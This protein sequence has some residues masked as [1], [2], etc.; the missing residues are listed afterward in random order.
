MGFVSIESDDSLPLKREI[1]DKDARL[2]DR[3]RRLAEQKAEIARLSR[4]LREARAEVDQAKL[5]AARA[6]ATQEARSSSRAQRLA[7]Q[8][9]EISRLNRE[10]EQAQREALQAGMVVERLARAHTVL[11]ELPSDE[12]RL[13]VGTRTT[14]ANFLANGMIAADRVRHVFGDHPTGLV[15]DWGC[16][17][18]R[19]LNWLLP[20]GSWREQYRGC[21]VDAQAIDWLAAQGFAGVSL[22]LDDGPLPYA[23]DTFEGVF[24]FSVLTHID[25]LKHRDWY[26]EIRRILRPGA[27]ALLTTQGEAIV[28]AARVSPETIEHYQQEGWAYQPMEGHYKAAA[29]ASPQYTGALIDELFDVEDFAVTGYSNMDAFVVRKR[30]D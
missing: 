7:E 24:A 4:E 18:G 20:V 3:A 25:P 22:C 29:L 13:H 21:D 17:S 2:L 14:S 8:K 10:L 5:V 27:K 1:R 28:Q 11:D 9:S 12:L 6:S 19:T 15:L 16:G 23:D 30:Q 26:L